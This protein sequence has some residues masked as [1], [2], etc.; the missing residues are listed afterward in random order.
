ME[1]AL[2]Q[3][4]EMFPQIDQDVILSALL[5]CEN[6]QNRALEL[7]L[8]YDPDRPDIL[9]SEH[10]ADDE[11]EIDRMLA[12]LLQAEWNAEPEFR[13]EVRKLAEERKAET[14]QAT[15]GAAPLKRKSTFKE[16]LRNLFKRKPKAA[17]GEPEAIEMNPM[18]GRNRE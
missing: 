6:D 7:L 5:S 2:D 16:K 4:R 8:N 10:M 17:T 14:S 11:E 13:E 12:E 9:C 3:L 15:S 1:S 18:E